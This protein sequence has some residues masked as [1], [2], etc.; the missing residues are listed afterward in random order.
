MVLR[1]VIEA[2]VESGLNCAPK[3]Q[4]LLLSGPIF[5]HIHSPRWVGGNCGRKRT[6]LQRGRADTALQAQPS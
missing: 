3:P 6:G 1:M 4:N 5:Q 2:K